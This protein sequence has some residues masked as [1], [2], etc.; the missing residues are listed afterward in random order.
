LKQAYI[1]GKFIHL[2]G[3]ISG[4]ESTIEDKYHL[5]NCVNIKLEVV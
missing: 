3:E 2:R 4:D 5:R 1:A